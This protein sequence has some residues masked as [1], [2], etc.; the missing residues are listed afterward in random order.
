MATAFPLCGMRKEDRE[1]TKADWLPLL[2]MCFGALESVKFSGEQEGL[3]R[4]E[5]RGQRPLR[6]Y[7]D[8]WAVLRM[9]V[10]ALGEMNEHC[11]ALERADTSDF[12]C[13][14]PPWVL[15]RA[16]TT[17]SLGRSSVT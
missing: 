12:L 6:G 13:D 4:G 8:S 2:D 10:S 5:V 11:H 14:R 3:Q 7:R 15:V 17:G 16:Q 9:A 1:Y